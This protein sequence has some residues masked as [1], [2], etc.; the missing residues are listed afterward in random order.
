MMRGLEPATDHISTSRWLA[1][2]RLSSKSHWCEGA[3][4][5]I[6]AVVDFNG[7]VTAQLPQFERDTLRAQVQPPHRID[8]LCTVWKLARIANKPAF[9]SFCHHKSSATSALMLINSPTSPLDTRQR[10]TP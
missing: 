3:N 6:T 2:G 10:R 1:T 4:N 9:F 7:D 8:T 5:G